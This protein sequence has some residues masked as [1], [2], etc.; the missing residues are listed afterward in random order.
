MESSADSVAPLNLLVVVLV[1]GLLVL[2]PEL[3][4]KPDVRAVAKG[5]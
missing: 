4:R 1:S 3:W 5:R 2:W